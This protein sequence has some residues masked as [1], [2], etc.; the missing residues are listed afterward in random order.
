MNGLYNLLHGTD[1]LVPLLLPALGYR[2]PGEVPRF[3]D[4]Y[5]DGDEI[6]I[7]TRTGGGNRAYYENLASCRTCY[8]QYFTEDVDDPPHGPWNDDLRKNQYYI[9]DEDDSFDSTYA[10]FHF[11]FPEELKAVLTEISEKIGPAATLKEKTEAV[12]KLL[13]KVP[14]PPSEDK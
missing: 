12:T 2:S 11:R 10:L 1:V 6:I 14:E 4:C 5:L 8:P 7:L 3:R 13:K 9:R